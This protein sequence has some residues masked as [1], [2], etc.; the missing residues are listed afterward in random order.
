MVHPHLERETICGKRCAKDQCF[1]VSSVESSVKRSNSYSKELEYSAL[2]SQSLRADSSVRCKITNKFQTKN[3]KSD[4]LCY[5]STGVSSDTR[6][7]TWISPANSHHMQLLYTHRS[8][9]H[10]TRCCHSKNSG[11]PAFEERK[12]R[13]KYCFFFSHIALGL[14]DSVERR[15]SS[16]N[17]CANGIDRNSSNCPR[18]LFP[19]C[20]SS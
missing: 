12:V 10:M 7:F 5:C 14:C 11:K 18:P 9:T 4:E 1:D 17:L 19:H 6:H 3:G 8:C 13:I 16:I 20:Q 15:R 2:H